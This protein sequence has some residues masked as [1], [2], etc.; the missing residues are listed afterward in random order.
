MI[1]VFMMEIPV[2]TMINWPVVMKNALKI[3]LEK[4]HLGATDVSPH[5]Y[6]PRSYLYITTE[7]Q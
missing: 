5:G 7:S 4:Y 2:S 1:R 3:S 6:N